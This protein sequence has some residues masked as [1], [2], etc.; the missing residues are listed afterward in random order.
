M[1]YFDGDPQGRE[2]FEQA[3]QAL[4]PPRGDPPRLACIQEALEDL[5]DP[6]EALE[7]LEARGLLPG[8]W[9]AAPRAFLSGLPDIVVFEA[10]S[11]AVRDWGYELQRDALQTTESGRTTIAADREAIV[12]F[13]AVGHIVNARALYSGVAVQFVQVLAESGLVKLTYEVRSTG[14]PEF[15]PEGP[16]AARGGE[17]VAAR[18]GQVLNHPRTLGHVCAMALRTE[19]ML[20][21]E[22]T[23]RELRQA[24]GMTDRTPQWAFRSV[25][26]DPFR[27]TVDTGF[28]YLWQRNIRAKDLKTLRAGF[29]PLGGPTALARPAPRVLWA[30]LNPAQLGFWLLDDMETLV[31][32][33]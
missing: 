2:R 7:V 4:E 19:D 32:P 10:K 1:S 17:L 3:V 15:P 33:L 5:H 13:E 31:C 18:E 26:P 9:S 25:Y 8:G 24:L 11:V 28:L 21:A 23:L 30:L 12:T 6:S 22:A 14:R 16:L 20:T 29:S 27:P